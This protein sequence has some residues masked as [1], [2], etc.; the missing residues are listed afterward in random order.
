MV[1][2]ADFSMLCFNNYSSRMANTNN[3]ETAKKNIGIVFIIT[4]VKCK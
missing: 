4:L 1:A 3:G 2:F